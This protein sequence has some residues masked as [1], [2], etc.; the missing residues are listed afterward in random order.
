MQPSAVLQATRRFG[1]NRR[2]AWLAVSV[3]VLLY[4]I[5]ELVS[6]AVRHSTGAQIYG[7]LVAALA[8]LA[9]AA[10]VYL[11]ASPRRGL[12]TTVAK[13][14]V[15]ALWAFVALGGIAGTVAHVVGRWPAT[16]RSTPDPGPFPHH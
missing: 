7:V 9:G 14:A 12:V 10:S 15:I 8:V 3:V 6:L 4:S 11:V 1:V 5:V 2:K 16:A 13:W